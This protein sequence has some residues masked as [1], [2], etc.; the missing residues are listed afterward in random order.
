MATDEKKFSHITVTS[1]DDV[2]IQAGIR[3][4]KPAENTASADLEERIEE[5]ADAADSDVAFVRE[6]SEEDTDHVSVSSNAQDS[7]NVPS[8][9]AKEPYRETTAEDLDLGPMP[10]MQKVII[11]VAVLGIVGFVAYYCFL[12]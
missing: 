5:V 11:A 10:L 1:D 4:S 7:E 9:R 8:E 3:S 2:V 12:R 6:S